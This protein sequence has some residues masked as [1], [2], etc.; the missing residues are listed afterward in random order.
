M[1]QGGAVTEAGDAAYASE[2]SEPDDEATLEEEEALIA[3]AGADGKVTTAGRF[4]S[5]CV[6]HACLRVHAWTAILPFPCACCSG[7][8]WFGVHG[9]R[10]AGS[11]LEPRLV[12]GV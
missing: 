12:Q 4:A 9:G 1:Q 7:S 3:E 5:G 11:C 8:V 6:T 2:E 10:C